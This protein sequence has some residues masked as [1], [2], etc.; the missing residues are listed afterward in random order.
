[1]TTLTDVTYGQPLFLISLPSQTLSVFLTYLL[2]GF[3]VCR[4]AQ[5]NIVIRKRILLRK[6]HLLDIARHKVRVKSRIAWMFQI[7]YLYKEAEEIIMKAFTNGTKLPIYRLT[8][9]DNTN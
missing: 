8:M 6:L 4:F 1:M 5:S 2:N 9:F 7:R 3:I